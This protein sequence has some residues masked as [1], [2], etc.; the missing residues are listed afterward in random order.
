MI[1]RRFLAVVV[2]FVVTLLVVMPSN[3]IAA[4]QDAQIADQLNQTFQQAQE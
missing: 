2:A 3:A 1:F 4:N